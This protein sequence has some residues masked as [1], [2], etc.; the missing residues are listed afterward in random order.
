VPVVAETAVSGAPGRVDEGAGDDARDEVGVDA[1]DDGQVDDGQNV[2]L[3]EHGNDGSGSPDRA[4]AIGWVAIVVGVAP[5]L[6]AG[7]RAAWRGWTPTGDNAYS[8]VRGWDVFSSQPP[9]LGTWSSA[10]LYTG[11]QIN[12]P[13]AL[14]FDLLAVPVHL[15]G[16]GPGT[17]V[18]MAMGN[19]AAVGLVGWLVL[20][21]LGGAAAATAMAFAGL[22]TWS[23]GSEM[24]YDPWSQYAPLLPFAL[25][26]VT[27]G[28]V[29]AG[30]LAALP[31][32]V[33]AGGYALQTHLSYSLLVPGLTGFALAAVAASSIRQRRRDA[34]GWR[35]ARGRTLRWT[36]IGAVTGL[37]VWAQP[38]VEQLSGAGEG[39]LAALARSRSAPAPTPSLGDSVRALGGTVAVP[40]A[41]LPPS[42]GSPSFH[43]DGSGR[44]TWLAAS[45]L[46]ALTLALVVLGVRAW[47][48]G[49]PA[50]AGATAT[51]L[52]ALVIGFMTVDRAPMR[53]GIVPTYLRWMWPLGMVVWL[54]VGLALL[55][56]VW[57]RRQA[58]VAGPVPGP[59][60][61]RP[62]ARWASVGLAATAVTAAATVPTVDNGTASPPWTVDA[63]HEVDDDVAAAVDGEPGVLVEMGG[64]LAV[65]ATAPALFGVLQE[66]GV[67]FYVHD[68]ALVRQL[69]VD[70]A[71]EPGDATVRLVVRGGRADRAR[72][73]ERLVAENDP[74]SGAEERELA[75]LTD[76]VR[77]IVARHGLPLVEDAR[78]VF[79]MLDRPDEV[80]RI[81]A[82]AD[83][84]DEALRSGLVR[85]LWANGPLVDLAG[86]PLLDTGVFPVELLDRWSELDERSENQVIHVYIAPLP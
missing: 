71:Y 30:D 52:A 61:G 77:E 40:P 86:G 84:P 36:A 43:L 58:R 45:G 42:Y 70:R 63:I 57:S 26:L 12:H 23:L 59:G 83:D 17:A 47:R 34:A 46:L 14:Q 5:I 13:G 76:E 31:I 8:A 33:V 54:A 85:L 18:G 39:N 51:A 37:A 82:V 55:D 48:R 73:G 35:R 15:L 72:P 66:A 7:V 79:T 65:G 6:L 9:L 24:L 41:W 56:E 74:L 11:H 53:F 62:T 69:G 80:D 78:S 20:R 2:E 50:V 10:S 44:P 29:V 25:F 75:R 67:P 60:L 3:D 49:S 38:L 27:V 19:A 1:V 64:H 4:R 22:L 21:S 28:C 16:H 81:A 32:M 68:V